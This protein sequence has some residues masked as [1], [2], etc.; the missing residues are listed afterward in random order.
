ML[1]RVCDHIKSSSKVVMFRVIFNAQKY[2]KMAIRRRKGCT[3]H[4]S[5][6]K[7][8]MGEILVG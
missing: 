2:I 5:I 6:S 7:C 1:F 4:S 3:K 8:S